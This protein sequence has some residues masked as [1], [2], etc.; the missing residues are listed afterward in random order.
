MESGS[1]CVLCSLELAF[2]SNVYTQHFYT[3]FYI[4]VQKS[5]Q[6]RWCH[7]EYLCTFLHRVSIGMELWII[8]FHAS[9]TETIFSVQRWFFAQSFS[10]TTVTMCLGFLPNCFNLILFSI[11]L[12]NS[13]FPSLPLFFSFFFCD[14][15]GLVKGIWGS[16]CCHLSRVCVCE[17]NCFLVA[18]KCCIIRLRVSGCTVE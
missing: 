14:G 18:W 6:Q 5:N 13:I 16:W 8:L 2:S 1:V 4:T 7:I 15:V 10:T 12:L 17:C 9:Q 11:I 3:N